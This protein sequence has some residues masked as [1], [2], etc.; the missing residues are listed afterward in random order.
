[1]CAWYDHLVNMALRYTLLL[2][3]V[4]CTVSAEQR[5]HVLAPSNIGGFFD[6]LRTT[7][8]A[9]VAAHRGGPSPGY[10]ENSIEAMAHVASQVPALH[11]IDIARTRDN[12]LVLMHDDTLD[13]T[14]T[15]TGD[16]R[17]HTLA[18][19]KALQLKDETGA[20][21]SHRVP[22]LREALDWAAGKVILELDV[23][24]GVSYEDVVA[25]V[26]AA[27]AISRVIFITYSTDAAVRVHQ[28]APEMMLSVSIESAAELAA[29]EARKVDLTRVLAW[30]G[31]ATV[32]ADLNRALAARGV[33][34]MFGTLGNPARSWDGRFAREGRDRY[35][36]F[37][38][39]GLQLISTDR[40]LDAAR[41]L[42][43]NDGV[44]G[45]AATL[46]LTSR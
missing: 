37:A 26:R 24:R 39:T 12:V 6:C 21:L 22:T 19:I 45:H 35:A 29:L 3:C 28:L 33:E 41:D 42:D 10:A 9:V 2:L 8:R 27:G 31:T 36:E 23:K 44:E 20:V 17:A 11:E 30:T 40:T 34:A 38:K 18:Q 4:V 16:V 7:G 46:C 14:T 13:R 43:A 5:T 25:E 1:M 32:N 15:G